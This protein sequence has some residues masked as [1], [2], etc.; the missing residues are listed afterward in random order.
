MYCKV[1]NEK[2]LFQY[3]P[4]RDSLESLKDNI[5]FYDYETISS[6]IPI[7][8]NT[9]PY[10]QVPSQVSVHIYNKKT[11]QINHFGLIL[12]P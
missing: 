9:R 6:P 2:E 10:Q 12:V 4:I 3:S 1:N 7:L 5:I 11:K 8:N